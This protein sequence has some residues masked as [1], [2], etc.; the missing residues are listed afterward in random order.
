MTYRKDDVQR[1]Y[2]SGHSG[3]PM[4]NVKVHTTQRE[5]WE[6]FRADFPEAAEEGFTEEWYDA[7]VTDEQ[8][9]SLFWFI[10]EARWE[11]L[12]SDAEEI[13]GRGVKVY[14]AG[15]SGGWAVVEG[16]GDVDDWDAVQLAK[17]RKWE[18]FARDTANYVMS[19]IL[20]SL[21]LN[22]WEAFRADE[23]EEAGL[24]RDPIPA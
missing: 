9:D 18:R 5:A 8:V 2:H 20:V 3:D 6:Q 15:H 24:H 11:D 23:R 22:E 13:F 7:N 21:Y 17:W 12:Q 1:S 19:E 10:C 14:S 4:A 16:L